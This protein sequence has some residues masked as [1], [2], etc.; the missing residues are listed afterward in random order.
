MNNILII[1][2]ENKVSEVI[3]VYLEREGYN[4]YCADTGLGGIDIFK[5][6]DF[7]LILLD[8]M[9]PDIDG[10]EVCKAIR[11]MSEVYI[12]ILTA[13]GTLNDKIQGLSIGAD[14]YFVKPFSPRELTV[15]VNAL[16]RR[17]N[18]QNKISILSFNKGNLLIDT[19]KRIVKV[20]GKQICLTPNEFD[21]LYILAKNKDMVLT[22]EQII[23]KAFGIDFQGIDR[24]IDVH[25]KNIRKKIEEDNKNPKYIVTVIRAGY[26][27]CGDF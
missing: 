11:K 21:I 19:E 22:R 20:K 9:L 23:I 8:L 27:F 18:K 6:V 10:E 16:F 14:D 13:K 26:K 24:T 2:D 17:I 15:R 25:I 4:V 3:K 1:E 5:K 12:F 7:Q